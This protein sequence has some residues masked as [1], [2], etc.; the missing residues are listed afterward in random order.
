MSSLPSLELLESTHTF[1]CRFTFKAI[2]SD[3]ENFTG[4]VIAS[5]RDHLAD[6]AEPSFS[7]RKTTSGRHLCV[8][9]EPNVDSAQTVLSIYQSLHELEGLVM[10]L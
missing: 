3:V 2:G 4:R 9:I 7:I 5:V 1:P 6:D 8:T 10:L